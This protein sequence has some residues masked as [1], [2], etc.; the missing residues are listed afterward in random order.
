M[1]ISFELKKFLRDLWVFSFYK[2]AHNG[3]VLKGGISKEFY[4]GLTTDTE[5]VLQVEGTH[6]WNLTS[7]TQSL[8]SKRKNLTSCRINIEYYL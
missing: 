7:A 4:F 5:P 3:K 6:G 2:I 8:V 1:N